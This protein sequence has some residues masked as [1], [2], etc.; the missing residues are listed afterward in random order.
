MDYGLRSVAVEDR[1]V[2]T[3]DGVRIALTHHATGHDQVLLIAHGFL[4]HR[5][6]RLFRTLAQR[7]AEDFDV[8]TMDFRGHGQSGGWYTFSARETQDLQA[9][10]DLI[11]PR[12][13]QLHVLAFSMGTVAAIDVAVHQRSIDRLIL[14]SPP[15]SFEAIENHWW[16]PDSLWWALRRTERGWPARV[17]WLHLPK[18]RSLELIARVAP[19]PVLFLHGSRD[20]IVRLRHSAALYAAAG[21]PKRLDVVDG[22]LHAEALAAQDPAGFL[23]RVRAWCSATND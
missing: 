21:A 19:A 14:V 17:G 3:R 12:Y 13:R 16:A 18:P 10:I 5:R 6:T 1:S 23:R 2:R 9:V 15:M 7:L 8:V 22:G 4:Q 20:P 11:R